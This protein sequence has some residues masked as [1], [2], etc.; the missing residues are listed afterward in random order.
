MNPTIALEHGVRRVR[1]L[2]LLFGAGGAMNPL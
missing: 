2:E 1:E